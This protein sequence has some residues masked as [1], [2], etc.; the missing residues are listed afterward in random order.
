MQP[1]STLEVRVKNIEQE[2]STIKKFTLQAI[3]QTSLPPF[4]G[5]SHITTY[6]PHPSGIL[7]RHYSIFNLTSEQGLFEIAVR[8]AEDSTG[9]SHYWHHIATI[10]DLL[11]VSF[12]K[13]YFPLSFQA[14][15]HA[16]YAAG[17]GIT[18]FLSMMADLA[19]KGCSFELHYAAKSKEDCAFYD[20]ISKTYPGQCHFYFSQGEDPRRLTPD[21]LLDHRIG[22][23]VYF[24]GPERMIQDFRHAAKAIGYPSFNI[25]FER[26]A[27][28][29][30]KEQKAFEVTLKNS[31]HQVEVPTDS[32][33]LDILHTNG[34]EVPYSCR[35]GGCGTCSVKVSEGEIIHFDSFLTEEQQRENRIMLSCVSRG[36]GR[37]VLDL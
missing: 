24:C 27:P 20:Y 7:E 5:G 9:G 15:H 19:E 32:S 23:H 18:P 17:I 36:K 37:L 22:T 35:V 33:L 26:F 12:P 2:T 11:T 1:K 3:D 28:P 29:S 25:H 14:K 8:L 10:G 31:S 21:L 13:N 4:S 30:M 6:L 34:I 16:L